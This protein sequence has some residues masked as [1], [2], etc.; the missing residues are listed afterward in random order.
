MLC[1]FHSPQVLFTPSLI[2]NILESAT[3]AQLAAGMKHMKQLLLCGEVVNWKLVHR[4]EAV[5]SNLRIFSEYSI[6]EIGELGTRHAPSRNN[7]KQKCLHM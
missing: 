2:Q 7:Q 5:N 3:A 4:L 6:A 1:W